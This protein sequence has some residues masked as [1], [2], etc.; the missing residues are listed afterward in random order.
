[1]NYRRL[2]KPLKDTIRSKKKMLNVSLK[3][4]II[5]AKDNKTYKS[6]NRSYFV[7]RKKSGKTKNAQREVNRLSATIYKLKQCSLK[8]IRY[9][10][11]ETIKWW[12][13]FTPQCLK[14]RL[15]IVLIRSQQEVVGLSLLVHQTS[16]TQVGSQCWSHLPQWN[17]LSLLNWTENHLLLL[18]RSLIA[19]ARRKEKE[20]PPLQ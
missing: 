7:K 2:K 17:L 8:W 20:R 16:N 14:K 19:G 12:K 5:W 9:S 13:G 3:N 15:V 4:T 18:V 11:I 1:M 10:K 6:L